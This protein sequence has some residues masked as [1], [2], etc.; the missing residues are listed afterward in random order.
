MKKSI[1]LSVQWYCTVK[2]CNISFGGMDGVIIL[3]ILS[4]INQL[5]KVSVTYLLKVFKID[6]FQLV[7]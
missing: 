4:F 6:G 3:C 7:T 2:K 1:L 5:H